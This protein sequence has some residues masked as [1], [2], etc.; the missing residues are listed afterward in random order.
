V[1]AALLLLLEGLVLLVLCVDLLCGLQTLPL[2]ARLALTLIAAAGA[3]SLAAPAA[4]RRLR[5]G[6]PLALLAAAAVLLGALGLTAELVGRRIEAGWEAGARAR[7][8]ERA[9]LLR[10]DFAWF[11][12]EVLRPAEGAPAQVADPRAA[13]E[14]LSWA[15]RRSRLPQDRY[16]LSLYRPDGSLLAWAGNSAPAPRDLIDRAGAAAGY[17]IAGGEAAP[18]L[19]AARALAPDG[20]RWVGE[21]LLR[22][23]AAGR[24]GDE[25]G[26]RLDFLPRWRRVAPA[27]V[28]VGGGSDDMTQF[29]L[30][31]GDRYWGRVGR[32]GVTTL[33][34]PLRAPDGTTLAVV[35]LKDRRAAREVADWRSSLRQAGSASTAAALLLAWLVW[36]ARGGARDERARLL[37]GSA[38]LWSARAILLALA[39]PAGPNRMPI[40]DVT[41]YA[42]S[43]LGGLL[44]SPADLLLT[45]A[46]CLGQA[47]L[48]RR[49]LE[50]LRPLGETRPRLRIAS[51][52]ALALLAI[53]GG[54]ALHRFLDRLVLDAGF[55][56]SRVT[57]DPP[58]GPRLALQ[59]SLF[60]L[61][62]AFALLLRVCA[63]LALRSRSDAAQESG[64]PRPGEGVLRRIPAA[65]R[66]VAGVLLLTLLYV[67]FLHHA[68]DRLRQAFFEEDL[69]P[70]VLHQREQRRQILQDS[71]AMAREPDFAALAG[72]A[73][74]GT[75]DGR[76]G[77]AYRLWTE[78]PLAEMGL[79]SSLQIFDP[80]GN[81]LSR[82]A[83]NLAPMLE[84]PFAAA[85]EAA[86]ADPVEVPPRPRATVKKPVLFGARWVRAAARPPLLLVMTLVDD[87]DNLP[88][89]GTETIYVQ[90]FG[91]RGLS[92]TNP[93]ILRFEPMVAVFGTHLARLYESGGEIPPPDPEVTEALKRSAFVWTTD[94][95]GDSTARIAYF[96][97]AE[98]IFALAH[99][100]PGRLEALAD[101][102]RLFL[103][104][105][106]LTVALLALAAAAG[107]MARRDFHPGPLVTT[108]YGRLMGVFLISALVPLLALAYFVTRFT[109][110]ELSRDLTA[111]GLG[112]LQVARRVAE[113][114]LT[115]SAP[116]EETTLDD[117]VVYWLSRVVRQDINVYRDEGLLATSTREL[118]TSGLLDARLDG[119]AYRSLYLEREPFRLVE[120]RVG[121]LEYLT[122]S[123]PMRIDRAG[124]IGVISIPLAAQRRAVAR[125]A[126][127]VEDAILIS[128]CVT[129]LLLA[130]MGYLVARRVSEPITL[131]AR[132][133][134]R[135]AQGDLDVRVGATASDE[136]AVLV[137]A[138][139]RMAA[140]LREQREDLR[141]RKDYIEKIVT[142][143]PTG[144]VSI[145]AAGRI[146]T[147]NPA[148]QTLLCGRPGSPSPDEN[149]DDCLRRD[150][151][152]AP[153]RAALRSALEASGERDAELV[154]ARG[155]SERRVRAV[156]LPFAPEEGSV[157]GRIILLE[158]VTEIVRSG[159]LAAWAEMA[160][161][162]AHEIKNP[163]TP[164]QLSVE[165]V[166]RL[167]KARDER[168]D[169]VLADCLENIE[170]QVR[171]LKQIAA[172]FSAY[173]R[174]PQLRPQPTTVRAILDEA[175]GPYIKAAPPGITLRV[176]APD[177]L[178]PVLVD[179]SVIARALVNLIENALQA[180][181][182]GGTLSV[183]AGLTD[184]ADGRPRVGLEVRDTGGG[185]DPTVLA[186][187]FEPYFSTKSEGTGLG[188][189]IARRAIEEHGGS[190]EIESRPGE[191]T[192]VSLTL[193]VAE[194][195]ADP[196]GS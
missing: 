154:L 176:A 190:I 150:P 76:R 144:V 34:F 168:F 2:W 191:G 182:E 71:L 163:L 11:L 126:E 102:L 82:F 15:R 70:R 127:E 86:G 5:S 105:G 169:R 74:E 112:S 162:I 173:A 104:N 23:P 175:L 88:M 30:K 185:I 91:A 143:A 65:L 136:T 107:R 79:A 45:A 160:R 151:T 101:Y 186:R 90:M 17:R 13:F 59:V 196:V 195:P 37:S 47:W 63:D 21:F 97:G 194:G 174:L 139:N 134:R 32:E 7:L 4:R 92:R 138:F 9:R 149:L 123:A 164:I 58:V 98:E 111:S 57:A 178:P 180:M 181:P 60:L 28:H 166:R 85:R 61:A 170:R 33:S 81:L 114:Y 3:I 54:L 12:D 158:D 51:V 156:F 121:G 1:T 129:V 167:W 16:G 6:A 94:D 69:A 67:P 26:L 41:L 48:V 183:S 80:Q 118:Y 19:W 189:A 142:S 147:I 66:L 29:F 155:E 193:P 93:E 64:P 141:R 72:F 75:E 25:G 172:E 145:D 78:T 148:A 100:H 117:D 171:T 42:S 44:G 10:E 40:F 119:E 115:V 62:A 8:E 50:R 110:R 131:L 146:M 132:A 133:A 43:S 179:R 38:A 157:P 152:L 188:L 56:V 84:M 96:K 116:E 53:G 108:F 35:S 39:D 106:A 46:A 49:F 22:F 73:E 55:D 27:H 153:L 184:G 20:P 83:L 24:R 14:T 87:Y 109:A 18:R 95:V 192:V 120:E 140:S 125:K 68:Y 52:A 31:Q 161:R 113:D 122:I 159:R 177:G 103:L 135:V 77:A 124:T 128:T 99:Y 130:G 165:H 137:D 36:I 187:L 89:L